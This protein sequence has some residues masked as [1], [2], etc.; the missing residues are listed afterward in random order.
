MERFVLNKQ[1]EFEKKN[2]RKILKIFFIVLRFF[3]CVANLWQRGKC[4]FCLSVASNR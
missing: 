1:Y 4:K 3:F 2:L